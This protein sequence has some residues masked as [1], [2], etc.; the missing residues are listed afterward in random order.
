ML[1]NSDAADRYRA[2][3]G[4]LLDQITAEIPAADAELRAGL[5]SAIVHGVIIDVQAG[6]ATTEPMTNNQVVVMGGQPE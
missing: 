2:A 6:N 1:T 3:A 4:P 5:L